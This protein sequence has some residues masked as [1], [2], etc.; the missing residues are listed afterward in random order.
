MES[1][2]LIVNWQEESTGTIMPVAELRIR[3]GADGNSYEFWYLRG[4]G[5]AMSKGFQPFAAFPD[6]HR[7]YRSAE[8]FPFFENRI[9]PSTRPDYLEY[10]AK[11]GLRSDSIDR[12]ELLARSGGRRQ[13]DR[14]ETVLAPERD[15]AGQYTTRF[16]VRGIRHTQGAEETIRDLASGSLLSAFLESSNPRN[17]RARLLLFAK[18]PIG[19]VPDYLLSDIDDLESQGGPLTFRVEKVNPLPSPVHHRVLVRLTAAWPEGFQPLDCPDF[20][21]YDELI[22]TTPPG[23]AD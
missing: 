11:L 23:L 18:G 8:L 7:R 19:Y 13:T 6:M 1:R 10:V 2:R 21:P 16:L 4:V 12:V 20:L 3:K 15:E 9:L 22:Q 14:I 17:S 5:V